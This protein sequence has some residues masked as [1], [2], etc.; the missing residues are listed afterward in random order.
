MQDD[1]RSVPVLSWF[2]ILVVGI[3]LVDHA[4]G[5]EVRIYP[6]YFAPIALLAWNAP[7]RRIAMLGPAIATLAWLASNQIADPTR[8]TP[9]IWLVNA[10]T[11]AVAF[12]TVGVLIAEVHEQLR[13]ERA[14]SRRDALTGLANSMAFHEHGELLIANAARAEQPVTL[15]YL[16]LD[17]FKAVNDG[18]GH[19]EG[20]RVLQAVA[21]VLQAQLRT[22]DVAARLGGD[23]FALLLPNSDGD[24]ARHLLERLRR[25]VLTRMREG[26]WPVTVSIGAVAYALA[27]PS[28]QVAI[29][30]ADALMYEAKRKGK[31]RVHVITADAEPARARATG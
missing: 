22:G 29:Q 16:D 17:N 21:A 8:F 12:F 13:R 2:T 15:A 31:D 24:G 3:A 30:R 23:E 9:G 26:G 14:L 25:A 6:L 7:R 4:T 19:I 20:D 28:L 18:K 11:Q 27:P 10:L 5:V 1:W